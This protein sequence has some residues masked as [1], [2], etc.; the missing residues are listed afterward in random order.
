MKPRLSTLSILA[1]S[2]ALC[3]PAAASAVSGIPASGTGLTTAQVQYRDGNGNGNGN[4]NGNR[5]SGNEDASQA[6]VAPAGPFEGAD[7][8]GDP[9]EPGAPGGGVAGRTGSGGVTQ[10]VAT[11]GREIERG[12]VAARSESSLPFTGATLMPVL[13]L[14]L[15]LLIAGVAVRG[16]ASQR[17]PAPA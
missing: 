17:A 2:A 11:D 4:S 3:F 13:L 1:I 8:A 12:V 15:A 5:R 9:G 10:T 7:P 6:G 14:G 16:R